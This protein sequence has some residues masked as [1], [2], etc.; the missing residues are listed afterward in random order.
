MRRKEPDETIGHIVEQAYLPLLRFMSVDQYISN[1]KKHVILLIC[2][3][4]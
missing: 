4:F 1:V 3:Q 2:F